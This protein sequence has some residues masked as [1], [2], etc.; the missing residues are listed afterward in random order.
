MPSK[1]RNNMS[2][3]SYILIGNLTFVIYTFVT[4]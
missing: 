2:S 4:F 3:S 1:Q